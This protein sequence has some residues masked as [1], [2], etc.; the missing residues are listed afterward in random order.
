MNCKWLVLILSIAIII[1]CSTTPQVNDQFTYAKSRQHDLRLSSY[2]TAHTVNNILSTEEGRREAVSLFRA[3]GLTKAY[4]EVYRGGLVVD[5]EILETVRDHFLDNDIDVV[6]GIATV[7]G[8]DF[9]VRQEAQ[10]GWF[11]WQNPKTQQDLEKVVRM[12]AEVFDVFIV[13]GVT[14]IPLS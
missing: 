3:N 14:S 1:S 13:D 7:P 9:G 8:G 2:I 4:I 10:L 11:N 5:K 12:S 6:G